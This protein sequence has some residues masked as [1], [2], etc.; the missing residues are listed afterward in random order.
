MKATI[1][2]Y[3]E[4]RGHAIRNVL[5]VFEYAQ[6]IEP[7]VFADFQPGTALH[8]QLK[9]ILPKFGEQQQLVVN[10]PAG[11]NFFN[12]SVP[13]PMMMSGVTF[14]KFKVDGEIALALN[15]QANSLSIICGEYSRWAQVLAE[16]SSVLGIISDWL[17]KHV[18]ASIFALQYLDEFKV[19]FED[20]VFRPLV[21]L[22]DSASP[23]L[24][25]NFVNVAQEFHS[26]HGFF[27]DPTFDVPGRL[28]TNVNVNVTKVANFQNV[29][30]QATHKYY[31]Q[32]NLDITEEG[33]EL[34]SL[35]KGVFEYLHQENK[36]I[37][38]SMLSSEVKEAISFSSRRHEE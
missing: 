36:E 34:S 21:D 11:G 32:A 8:A 7:H 18:K 31:A 10:F 16:V 14:E 12:Q 2:P 15:I 17:S 30:I 35:L 22:F 13:H 38:G 3:N 29:Q 5:F 23:Y 26:H 20:G 19:T 6:P 37:I 25:A 33:R 4:E 9:T 24:T 27:S 28:L 1:V